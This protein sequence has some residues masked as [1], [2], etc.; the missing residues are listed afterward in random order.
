MCVEELSKKHKVKQESFHTYIG[1]GVHHKERDWEVMLIDQAES[2]GD[3]KRRES[4]WQHKLD[5]FQSNGLNERQV[6]FFNLT[7]F[8]MFLFKL[9]AQKFTPSIPV[10]WKKPT[11][12]LHLS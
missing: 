3:L 7:Q 6:T 11:S 4:C 9:F 10:K 1:E 8:H 5:T 12:I 2:V